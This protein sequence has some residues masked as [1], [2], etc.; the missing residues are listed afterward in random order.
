MRTTTDLPEAQKC[1]CGSWV[2]CS[3][4]AGSETEPTAVPSPGDLTLCLRCGRLYTYTE[5]MALAP[6]SIEAL[7]P[8]VQSD[9][10]RIQSAIHMFFRIP[11]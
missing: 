2:E 4:P 7:P 11:S 8:N 3:T 1:V 9:I 5:T 10:R 6:Q